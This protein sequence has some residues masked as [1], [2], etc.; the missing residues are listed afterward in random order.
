MALPVRLIKSVD[1]FWTKPNSRREKCCL[2]PSKW[3][4]NKTWQIGS[5]KF[6]PGS[7]PGK[8]IPILYGHPSLQPDNFYHFN[9]RIP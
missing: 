1:I 9:R 3:Y 4:E 2:A 7:I 8:G 5:P 6:M